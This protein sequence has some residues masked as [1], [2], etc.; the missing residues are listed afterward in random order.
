[1]QAYIRA[2]AKGFSRPTK[3]I[4][5]DVKLEWP[6]TEAIGVIEHASFQIAHSK[7]G[8]SLLTARH[9][10]LGPSKN[11]FPGREVTFK[12]HDAIQKSVR[13]HTMVPGT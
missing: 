3:A 12:H 11:F 5:R 8:G 13:K 6:N 9:D 2:D 1:L 10:H 7:S 4:L